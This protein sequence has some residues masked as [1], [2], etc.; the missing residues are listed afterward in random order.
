MQGSVLICGVFKGSAIG[1]KLKALTDLHSTYTQSLTQ[2]GHSE[3]SH[4]YLG[5]QSEEVLI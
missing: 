4:F 1:R 3:L 5:Q 2:L